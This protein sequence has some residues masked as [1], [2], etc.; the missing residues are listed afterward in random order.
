MKDREAGGLCDAAVRMIN[1][2]RRKVGGCW[3]APVISATWQA[4][5]EFQSLDNTVRTISK[6][7][8]VETYDVLSDKSRVE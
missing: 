5:G 7:K 4:E 3:H 6:K 8:T 1:R 2:C